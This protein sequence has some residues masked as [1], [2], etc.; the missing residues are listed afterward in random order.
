MDDSPKK[1]TYDASPL[2]YPCDG[3]PYAMSQTHSNMAV[4]KHD[5][6]KI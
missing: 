2:L 4:M 5:K 3:S 6:N 1:E